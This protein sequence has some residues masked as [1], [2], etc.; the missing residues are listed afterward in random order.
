MFDLK[1]YLIRGK[2]SEDKKDPPVNSA[3]NA[4]RIATAI[5]N[6]R[7]DI[8]VIREPNNLD[9][10]KNHFLS[11]L[12]LIKQYRSLPSEFK[13]INIKDAAFDKKCGALKLKLN[14]FYSELSKLKDSYPDIDD[15][16]RMRLSGAVILSK[17]DSYELSRINRE[18]QELSFENTMDGEAFSV[19]NYAKSD[20]EYDEIET[21]LDKSD[22]RKLSYSIQNMMLN[23][24]DLTDK[25]VRTA[26]KASHV[27]FE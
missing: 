16:S 25:T 23:F 15:I 24:A 14:K 27:I 8:M 5:K 26:Y 18:I 12:K 10:Y 19:L 3:S 9:P 2:K 11:Y 1:K 22:L 17:S 7:Q 20:R 4:E 13:S 21:K 6:S